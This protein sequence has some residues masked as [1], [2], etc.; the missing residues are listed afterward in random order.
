MSKLKKNIIANL[1][2]QI[3]TVLV[4]F[5][6]YKYIYNDLGG[7]ALGII[8]FSMMISGLLISVIDMGI[9][10][11]TTKEIAKYYIDDREYVIGL[12][13]LFATLYWGA[14][15]LAAFL[16]YVYCENIVENWINVE[17]LEKDIA[18]DLLLVVGIT[19]LLSLPKGYYTSICVGLQ[20]MEVNNAIDVTVTVIQQVGI[21]LL[22]QFNRNVVEIGYW[23]GSTNILRIFLYITT[24]SRIYNLNGIMFGV[25]L[26][27]LLRVK[28]YASKMAFLSLLLLVHKQLDK[29][30]ISKFLVV[31][32]VGFYG[33]AYNAVSKLALVTG[34]IAQ[35]LFPSFAELDRDEDKTALLDQFWLVQEGLVIIML[36]IFAAI[37]FFSV[38]VF[39]FIFDRQTAL[40]LELPL[41]FLAIAFYLNASLRTMSVYLT[42]VGRPK[43]IILSNVLSLVFVTPVTVYLILNHQLLGAALSWVFYY[44]F[45]I[46]FITPRAY[47]EEINDSAYRKWLAILA[48]PVFGG[49]AIILP[50]WLFSEML[51]SGSILWQVITYTFSVLLYLLLE[52]RYCD[53][54]LKDMTNNILLPIRRISI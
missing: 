54:R 1:I 32:M 37:P 38:S 4:G 27:S 19:S 44:V 41:F 5:I 29:L 21:I 3:I 39:S 48:K 9:S 36:P 46:I 23:I 45:G 14:Y 40:L 12:T 7:D 24:V 11:T 50:F 35:A 51:L 16:F 33:I 6:A 49:I 17:A 53:K 26:S 52:S 13:R 28:E 10:K 8:V 25:S 43:Y 15:L 2:G 31:S 20:R 18:Y 34:A 47:K 22:L 42:A 30:L